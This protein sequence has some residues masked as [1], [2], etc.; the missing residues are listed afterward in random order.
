MIAAPVGVT[1]S[2]SASSARHSTPRRSSI[3]AGAGSGNVPCVPETKPWNVGIGLEIT[4]GAPISSRQMAAPTMSM[5]A[6]TAPTS[7]KC[8]SSTDVPWTAASASASLVNM[9]PAVS[10][11]QSESRER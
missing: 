9:R 7:W 1:S 10:L 4:F 11:T 5:M 2:P 6:S 8:T 3:V